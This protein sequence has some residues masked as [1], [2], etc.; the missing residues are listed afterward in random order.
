MIWVI[1]I[2]AFVSWICLAPSFLI[3]DEERKLVGGLHRKEGIRKVISFLGMLPIVGHLLATHG[4]IFALIFLFVVNAVAF[5]M[6][7][8]A[9]GLPTWATALIAFVAIVFSGYSY[10]WL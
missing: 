1:N 7:F 9:D 5:S 6:R 3:N 10:F 2:V 4:W 8:F